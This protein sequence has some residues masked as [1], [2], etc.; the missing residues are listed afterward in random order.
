M[1]ASR[2]S[3][4][5]SLVRFLQVVPIYDNISRSHQQSSTDPLLLRKRA[6][7]ISTARQLSNLWVHTQFLSHDSY[8]SSWKKSSI[9]CNRLHQFTGIISQTCDQYVQYLLMRSYP[10]VLNRHRWGLNFLQHSPYLFQPMVLRFP[11]MA[12]S[13]LKLTSWT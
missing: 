6:S 11:L 1:Y 7:S 4:C 2:A 13:G 3:P 10:S 5:T 12:S 8:W 9:C